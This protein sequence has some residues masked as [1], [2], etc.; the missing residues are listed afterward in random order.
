MKKLSPEKRCYLILGIFNLVALAVFLPIS[1]IHQDLW[2]LTIGWVMGMAVTFINMILL[3][4]TGDLIT[5]QAKTKHGT[6]LAVLFYFV[7]FT[8]MAGVMVTCALLQWVFKHNFFAWSIFTCAGS[9]LP[10]ALIIAIFYHSD[11]HQETLK[12]K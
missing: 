11:E 4:K 5:D 6:A 9:V 7:R 8:L 10:S 12:K 3:F 1:I 2:G